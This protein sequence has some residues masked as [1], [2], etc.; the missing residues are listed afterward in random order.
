[1]DRR[2]EKKFDLETNPHKGILKGLL[3]GLSLSHE[4]HFK[5]F[6]K[7]F[8]ELD[9]TKGRGCFLNFVGAPIILKRKKEIYCG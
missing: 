1:L 3:K 5:N 8:T 9:L 6:D 7:K 4:I 2:S